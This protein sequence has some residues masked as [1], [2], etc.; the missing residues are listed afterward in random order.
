MSTM[1]EDQLNEEHKMLHEFW[2]KQPV[3][4]TDQEDFM[5]G[6]I[7]P[8]IPESCPPN[9]P[10]PL[11]AKFY[12]SCIDINDEKQLE[13]VYNFLSMNYVE[14]SQHRFRFRLRASVLKWALTIPGYIPDW[15]FGVRTNNGS[16]VG[17]ISGIPHKI[18]LHN[19]TQVWCCVNFLCVHSRLRAKKM[20]PILIFEL[21]RRVR[22]S[23]VY[24]AIFSGSQIPSKPFSG[25]Y[26]S[27]RP[28][29]IKKLSSS[30]FYPVAPNK[31]ASCNKRFAVPALVHGNLRIMTADDVPKVTELLN[32]TDSEYKFGTQFDNDLVAHMFLPRDDSV[33]SYVIPSP[34]G[35]KGFFS[36]YIMDWSILEENQMQLTELKAAY[37][38]YFAHMGV[39]LKNMFADLVHC[40]SRDA[41]VD[42]LN[43]LNMGGNSEALIVNK[44]E[45]GSRTLDYY[46]YNFAVNQ[47]DPNDVRF[48]FI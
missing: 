17:F 20:A 47:I 4:K 23:H 9:E 19:D 39:D 29:N 42:I 7:D 3:V 36:F 16:L 2:D 28:I 11:P 37:V 25:A 38:H 26:Y 34:N 45:Q 30:G 41:R 8:T 43:A 31:I 1:N 40:A 33:F 6:Y 46:S 44:F 35:I 5:V 48:I 12:W 21:A 32:A 18:R 22:V 24:R 14:D 10:T 13:D 27:H 15:I